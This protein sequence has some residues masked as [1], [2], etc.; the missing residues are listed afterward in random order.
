MRRTPLL[1]A[2]STKLRC[3][4]STSEDEGISRN[5]LSTPTRLRA[6]LCGLLKS[7]SARSNPGRVMDRACARLRTNARTDSPRDHSFFTNSVPTLPL[8]PVTKIISHPGLGSGWAAYFDDTPAPPVP[9]H[10]KSV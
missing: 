10:S 5:R 7:P 9:Y 8:A 3:S 1:L 2:A 6:T 4:F